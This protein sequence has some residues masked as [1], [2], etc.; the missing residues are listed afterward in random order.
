MNGV[1]L[2]LC[3]T[4]GRA[5]A[6]VSAGEGF[7]AYARPSTLNDALLALAAGGGPAF[8][9]G[10]D[11]YPA[12]VDRPLPDNLVDVTAIGGF[13]DITRQG[14]AIRIGA[15]TRWSDIANASLPPAFDGLKLAAREVGS[16]QIQNRG[17]IGG[18]LCNASPA[19]DGVPPLLTLNAE[20]ELASLAGLR[21]LALAD[22]ITG[23]RATALRPGELLTAV[24]VPEP[25]EAA[26]A[27]FRKLGAR[28]YL[29]ISIVMAAA[30]IWR[31][32]QGAIAGVRAAVG[33][34]SAVARRLPQ[35]EAA[36]LGLAPGV[37]PS[38]LL[39]PHHLSALSPI[40][41][42][43]ASAAYRRHAA[44]QLLGAVLDQAA[45]CGG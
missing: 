37:A 7:L 23:Y 16:L 44:V 11:I 26:T 42:V 8:A 12:H 22:F 15:A 40:D 4:G 29:V 43:R 6:T 18:N 33:A 5:S 35:L 14:G 25:P 9:G 1:P 21:R 27:Y 17:T 24:I 13:S 3:L 19:A 2:Q 36:L 34:A 10:T 31:D 45:G 41:D 39:R 32:G 20:V 38:S 28:R 30:V